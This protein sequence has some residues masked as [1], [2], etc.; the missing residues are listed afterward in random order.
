MNGP[1]RYPSPA[2]APVVEPTTLKAA[3]IVP[4][5]TDPVSHSGTRRSMPTNRIA[6][7][8]QVQRGQ[9]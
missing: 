1:P 5:P 6:A 7:A 2:M 8:V 3:A 4:S 9:D